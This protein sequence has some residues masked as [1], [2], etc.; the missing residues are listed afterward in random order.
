M[1]FFASFED[2]K[3]INSYLA[4]DTYYQQTKPI[5]GKTHL[6]YRPLRSNRRDHQYKALWQREDAHG[7]KYYAAKLYNTD[8]IEYHPDHIILNTS[9]SWTSASTKEFFNAILPNWITVQLHKDQF[10][11]S[12]Y[13]SPYFIPK[14]N[15]RISVDGS[16][17]YLP[18]NQELTAKQVHMRRVNRKQANAL[19]KPMAEFFEWVN[20]MEKL[21][22]LD[23]MVAIALDYPVETS[24]HAVNDEGDRRSFW[25]TERDYCANAN[26]QIAELV[27][28][29]GGVTQE[30]FPKLVTLILG[31]NRGLRSNYIRS[32]ADITFWVDSSA[33]AIKAYTQ[34]LLVEQANAYVWEHR[35][36]DRSFPS[37]II[38]V[39]DSEQ[40]IINRG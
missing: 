14:T 38:R 17:G 12:V 18:L 8:L 1:S 29:A 23:Q 15:L 10:W 28:K 25:Q 16:D 11:V 7:N 34:K 35:A 6:N 30:D 40:I 36:Y 31:M 33:K 5:R 32:G 20:A 39:Q 37:Q 13:G 2:C 27:S 19:Y 22:C 26:G 3:R 9:T 21:E 4:A 24:A